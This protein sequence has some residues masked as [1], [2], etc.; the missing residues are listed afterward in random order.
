MK[1]KVIQYQAIS[2]VPNTNII[3]GQMIDKKVY[4]S[5]SKNQQKYINIL[6]L[7]LETKQ[8]KDIKNLYPYCELIIGKSK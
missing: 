6:T 1:S 7:E 8:A 4:K 2:K 5:L 3:K